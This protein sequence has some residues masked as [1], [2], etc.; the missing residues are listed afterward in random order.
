MGLLDAAQAASNT[1]AGNVSAPV[2]LIA[3]LLRKAGVPVPEA[4]VGGSDWMARQGLTREVQPGVSKL[5]GETFGLL[6]PTVVAAKAPQIAQ[7][8]LQHADQFQAYNKALGP[9]G[10]SPA[11]VWHG[12]PHKFDKFD[13]SKIGT[14]EGAQAYGHGLYLAD[15]PD[16]A[17][18]YKEALGGPKSYEIAGENL[19]TAGS[20][21]KARAVQLYLSN[22]RDADAAVKQI[23]HLAKT[24][25]YPFNV[26]RIRDE[27]TDT[28]KALPMMEKFGNKIEEIVPGNLYKADLPDSMIARMLDWDK[29]LSQQAPEVQKALKTYKGSDWWLVNKDRVT[30]GKL[31]EGIHG[32]HP[33][34]FAGALSDMGIPGIKYLDGGSRGAGVGSHNYVLFPGEEKAVTILERNGQPLGLLKPE[35]VGPQSAALKAAQINAAKPM[36]EGG[37]GLGPNNTP[38]ERAKAMG[39]TQEGFRGSS[40]DEHARRAS[41]WWS[42]NK[43]LANTYAKS[44]SRPVPDDYAGNVMPVLVNTEG[45]KP[46]ESASLGGIP[47]SQ[48]MTLLNSGQRA[49]SGDLISGFRSSHKF[50]DAAG[51]VY[52]EIKYWEALSP[53]TKVRS[54]FAAFDPAKRDSADILAGL[55]GPALLAP[56]LLGEDK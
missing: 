31:A 49:A 29:P 40:A 20:S 39:F 45:L 13:S 11:T 19:G 15:A 26:K 35:V 7:G 9:A 56:Y 23:N 5:A 33:Q 10:A 12:S 41:S 51:N 30:G 4:P 8:L 1:V 24:D 55:L 37:L 43:D 34:D 22:G 28:I 6:A 53:S 17:Q 46:F 42:E 44:L 47:K 50:T 38:M 3:W 54:R 21:T 2:D 18:A 36:S 52:P 14:G 16:V 27:L 25:M 32:K 48:G